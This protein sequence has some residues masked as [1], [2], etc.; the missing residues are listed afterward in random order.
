MLLSLYVYLF[1]SARSISLFQRYK[2]KIIRVCSRSRY[3]RRENHSFYPS[4]KSKPS[5]SR[6]S[7][8]KLAQRVM[9]LTD[10]PK[11]PSIYN[12]VITFI[13]SI[14]ALLIV[15]LSPL[16]PLNS[17]PVSFQ[18]GI[19][20]LLISTLSFF[21]LEFIISKIAQRRNRIH[22]AFSRKFNFVLN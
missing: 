8:S 7:D 11:F 19:I 16:A 5:K 10:F 18:N 20:Y 21:I 2:R 13:V 9:R 22:P 6:N 17:N 1:H 15:C 14:V 12:T 3:R 4:A